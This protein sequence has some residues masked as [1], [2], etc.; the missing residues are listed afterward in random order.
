VKKSIN[1]KRAWV[2]FSEKASIG[3]SAV[4]AFLQHFVA[5]SEVRIS[6]AFAR[7]HGE[8]DDDPT[9]GARVSREVTVSS[10]CDDV[11]G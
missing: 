8:P 2:N 4:R 1:Y 5:F 9:C 7:R 6:E 11:L 3:S 10:S